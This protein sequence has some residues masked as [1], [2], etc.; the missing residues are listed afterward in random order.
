M[1]ATRAQ[2]RAAS[3]GPLIQLNARPV[4][5]HT[6]ERRDGNQWRE[7]HEN[8]IE[9]AGNRDLDLRM[10]DVAFLRM[11]RAGRRIAF[12][13]QGRSAGACLYSLGLRLEGGLCPIGRSLLVRCEGLLL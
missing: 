13:Q 2:V 9:N 10:C 1:A 7:K 8:G 5:R 11:V 3:A 4:W 12:G 6:V